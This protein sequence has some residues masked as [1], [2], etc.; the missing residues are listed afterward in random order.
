MG[1]RKRKADAYDPYTNWVPT[2]PPPDALG[3]S[4]SYS[5]SQAQQAGSSSLIRGSRTNPIE[6][7]ITPPPSPAPLPPAKK[8]RKKKDPQ[9]EAPEKRGAMFKKQCPQN[10]RERVER[11]ISQRYVPL[12][13]SSQCRVTLCALYYKGC[14][15]A[16]LLT[17]STQTRCTQTSVASQ[18]QL[19]TL[20]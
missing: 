11:V 7:D 5:A 19:S 1:A 3:S 8:Q 15:K 9:A 2:V 4:K 18:Y 20:L 16:P 6:L 17:C 14:S 13:S 10:I 12:Q